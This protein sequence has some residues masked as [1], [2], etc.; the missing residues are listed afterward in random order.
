MTGNFEGR[1]LHPTL[2]RRKHMFEILF[3]FEEPTGK[4]IRDPEYGQYLS[5]HRQN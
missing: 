4:R 1:L 5:P 3:L 2:R